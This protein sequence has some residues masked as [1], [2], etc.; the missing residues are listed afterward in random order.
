VIDRDAIIEALAAAVR[1]ADFVR[2][3]WLGGSDATGRTDALSDVDLCLIVRDERVEDAF[4]LVEAALASLAPIALRHR[5]PAPI[6][7]GHGQAF[8]ALEGAA[9]EA[10]IDLVVQRVGADPAT[11]FLERERHGEAMVLL[12]RD[13]LVVPQP[14][15]RAA[16]AARRRARLAELRETF[17]LFQSLV[18]TAIRRGFAAEAVGSYVAF[19]LRPLVE[20]LRIAHC[21]DRF[22]YGLRY[23]DRDLP[24]DL[25]AQVE[26]LALAPDL[27]ALAERRREAAALFDAAI[28]VAEDGPAAQ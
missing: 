10:M 3:A 21:P 18:E 28:R 11:R 8:Y 25:R 9:S 27:Q 17:P 12:D 6:W 15:D 4:G 14:L 24:P 22:D 20:M 16:L 2:A 23:L 5:L 7:L 1:D 13:G 19:T 26:R